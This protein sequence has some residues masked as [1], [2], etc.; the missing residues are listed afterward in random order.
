MFYGNESS[1]NLIP[2]TITMNFLFLILCIFIQ[3]TLPVKPTE[4]KYAIYIDFK[5]SINEKRFY[6]IN[7]TTGKVIMY[8]TCA[9]AGNSGDQY[10]TDFSNDI[11]TKKTSLGHYKIGEQYNGIFG[12]AIKLDGLDAINSNARTR[13]I[14]IH[15]ASRMSTKWSWGCFAIPETDM[16]QLLQLELRGCILYAFK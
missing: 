11:G 14:V 10:A 8:T 13:N 6:V 1:R 12:R 3:T 2:P 5:K 7:K 4:N 9:H 15:S 16:Q